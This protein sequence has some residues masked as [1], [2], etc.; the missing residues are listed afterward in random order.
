[1][2]S[3]ICENYGVCSSIEAELK[4][5][6]IGLRMARQLD[7]KKVWLQMDSNVLVGMLRGQGNWSPILKPLLLKCK[8]NH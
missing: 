4:A 1:M 3:R 5:A 7:C 2:D 6:F 8:E